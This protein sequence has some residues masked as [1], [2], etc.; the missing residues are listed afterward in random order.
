MDKIGAYSVY[1]KTYAEAM[2]GAMANRMDNI[3]AKA[4]ETEVKKE[5]QT[6]AIEKVNLSN[7]AKELLKELQKKYGN[8]DF[9]VANYETS[10]EAS[11][12]LARGTKEYSVLIDP[13]TLEK[14][15]A[16][17][18]E[19]TKYMNLLEEATGT[20]MDMKAKLEESG[21]Q[22]TR[23]GVSIGENGI[24]SYFAQLEQM[25]EKQRERI[26]NA[27]EAGK[28]ERAEAKE[29]AAQDAKK[30]TADE[31]AVSKQEGKEPVWIGADTIKSAF[32]EAPTAVEL[33]QKARNMDWRNVEE[34]T[35]QTSGKYFDFTV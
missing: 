3:A 30:D 13:D 26:E 21:E 16:D 25:S 7:D 15:A 1:Q 9:M 27:R 31:V 35:F 33:F 34:R 5:E 24:D 14:M 18:D 8:M 4:E 19:K 29:E 6:K 11:S 17:E 28:Q 32:I 20:L 12:L 10:Q 23:L 22:V 2:A